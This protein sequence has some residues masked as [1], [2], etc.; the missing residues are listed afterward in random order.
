M[1]ARSRNTALV[2]AAVAVLG[3]GG[4]AGAATTERVVYDDFNAPG[5]SVANFLAK[6]SNSYGPGELAVEGTRSFDGGRVTVDATPFRTGQDFSVFDHLKYFA[7]ANRQFV[8]PANGSM[9]YSARVTASTPGTVPG[10]AINGVYG[11]SG[12]WAHPSLGPPPGFAPF[13]QSLL[14]GQQAGL[15]TNLI[16]FCTGQ[17]FD[18]FFSGTRAFT[19]IE[20]LPSNVTNNTTSS[21]CPNATHVG[22]DK[23]YTQ[24]IDEFAITPGRTYVA[25]IEVSRKDGRA[26][27]KYRLDNEVVSQVQHIGVPLDQQGVEYTGYA[28]S[29]GPGEDIGDELSS[30]TIAHGLFSLLDAFPYQHP[31]VIEQSVSIPIGDSTPAV[32]GRARLF[33]QGAIGSWD[34][35]TVTTVTA[36]RG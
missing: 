26:S 13:S 22:R 11:P 35:F 33:G 19:L 23:M 16:D 36:K 14:E 27:V 17:L 34:D 6:W 4:I 18:W 20:R 28:P 2:V 15:A 12:A 24:I 10:L 25:S 21:S 3:G 29:L 32:A 9:T 7:S 5:Y 30:F 1:W 8:L 31:E